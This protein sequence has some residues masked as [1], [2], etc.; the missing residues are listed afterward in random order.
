MQE[1]LEVMPI[2]NE[3]CVL[4]EGFNEGDQNTEDCPTGKKVAK[5]ATPST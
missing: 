5:R 2:A 3:C 4:Q 1:I